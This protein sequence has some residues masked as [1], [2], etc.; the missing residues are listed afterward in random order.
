MPRAAGVDALILTYLHPENDPRISAAE[1][2]AGFGRP[3]HV[4]APGLTLAV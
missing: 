4:G 2:G 1:G 3:V